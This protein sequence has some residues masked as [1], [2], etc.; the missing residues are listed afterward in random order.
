MFA[1]DQLV[2]GS[3]GLVVPFY[4]NKLKEGDVARV[5]QMSVSKEAYAFLNL[6]N[7]Q[8]S[9]AGSQ[10]STPPAP[11][12]GNVYNLQKTSDYALG[13]FMVSSAMVREI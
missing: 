1:K 7:Q 12:R 13:F 5:E 6:L 4:Q 2:D 10:F 11:I 3:S 9:N 8:T